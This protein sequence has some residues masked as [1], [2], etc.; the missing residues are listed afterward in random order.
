MDLKQIK[1][2]NN[3]E[4]TETPSVQHDKVTDEIE[5]FVKARVDNMK[6]YRKDL[7]IENDWRTADREY[8]PEVIDLT[9][10]G[11]RFETDDEL[12]LRTRL[13]PIGD[14]SQEWRSNNSDP[15]LMVKIQTA[16]SIIIDT[17]PKVYLPL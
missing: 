17:I 1:L 16:L 9:G 2:H 15:T 4:K 8:I 5:T 12:G 11:K 6:D 13:V 14:L 7:R 3:P 10:R